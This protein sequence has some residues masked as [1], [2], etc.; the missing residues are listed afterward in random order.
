MK[1][2]IDY[3]LVGAGLLVGGIMAYITLYSIFIMH[4]RNAAIGGM[5]YS[6]FCGLTVYAAIRRIK[7]AKREEAMRPRDNRP[8]D[9]KGDL[10]D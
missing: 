10:M 4:D 8:R 2:D 1:S 5:V 6:L 3:I 9:W 7:K